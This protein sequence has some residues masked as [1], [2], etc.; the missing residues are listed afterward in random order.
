MC[1]QQQHNTLY[2][3]HNLFSTSS[4]SGLFTV[5]YHLPFLSIHGVLLSMLPHIHGTHTTFTLKL[6]SIYIHSHF[7]MYVYSPCNNNIQFNPVPIKNRAHSKCHPWG[8]KK[9]ILY[10]RFAEQ[11]FGIHN[12]TSKQWQSESTDYTVLLP[13]DTTDRS[14]KASGS[15]SNTVDLSR[16]EL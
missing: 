10:S 6:L 11:H 16:V 2:V 12:T 8:N 4:Y 7:F 9:S 14:V 1:I 3:H 5:S 13:I 15:S